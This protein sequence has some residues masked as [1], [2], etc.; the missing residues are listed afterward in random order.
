MKRHSIE[1]FVEKAM[2]KHNNFYDYSKF[3]YVNNRTK[4]IIGCPIH[5]D[6]YQRPILH[7]CGHGCSKCAGNEPSNKSEFIENATK[8][9]GIVLDYSKF[10]YVNYGTK[11]III[12]PIHGEFAQS[13]NEHLRGRSCPSCGREKAILSK[14]SGAA[15]K[16]YEQIKSLRGNGYD[17]SKSKYVNYRTEV[18]VICPLHGEFLQY[19][20]HITSGGCPKCIGRNKISSEIISEFKSKHKNE[21]DYSEVIY[22]GYNKKVK[23][24]CKKHWSFWQAPHIHLRGC[25]CPKCGCTIS[26]PEIQFLTYLGIPDT[27]N[28]RQVRIKQYKIDGYDPTT[29]TVY[30][31]LGDYWHGNPSL[32][33]SSK[34]HPRIKKTY[35]EVYRKTIRRLQALK[36]YG[37]VV[38]YI[39]EM[40]WQKYMTNQI[41]TPIINEI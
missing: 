24:I 15:G 9:H 19:P 10:T 18:I 27:K 1:S 39:W 8:K 29:N 25:G 28:T 3:I 13:P 17:Y 37:Y 34:L 40:D 21:Y 26:G 33:D 22:K 35:G 7:L 14:M 31:F 5:G 11:G 16:F 4:G 36:T 2:A 23:I 38:K 41:T 32:Y 12:C 20:Q 30:E 6:F